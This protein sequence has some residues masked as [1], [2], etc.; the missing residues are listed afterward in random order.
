SKS[1][2][3]LKK[4]MEAGG[5]IVT[6]GSSTGLAYHLGLPVRNAITV[7]TKAGSSEPLPSE[8]FFIPGSLL[9]VSVDTTA[10]AS[11]GMSAK[12][13]VYFDNTPVFTVSPDAIAKGTI[14]PLAWFADPCPLR[15]G[16][17]W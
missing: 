5:K 7:V 17:A 9:N 1:I 2:P 11:W 15:S 8:K 10:K 16:W 6:I 12:T 13:D 4:F 3:Q 14:N